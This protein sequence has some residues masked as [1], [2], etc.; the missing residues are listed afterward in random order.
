VLDPLLRREEQLRR[1]YG[2][3]ILARVPKEP[4]GAAG[5]PLSPAELTSAAAEAYRTLRGTLAV[6]RRRGSGDEE[7]R[8]I[9]ITGS[10]PAEGKTTT[11]INLATSLAAAGNSVILIEADL[12]R[13]AIGAALDIECTYGIVSV[14]IESVPLQDALVTSPAFG[15]NL[16]MLLADYEG[17]WISELFTLPAAPGLLDDARRLAD[18]VIVDSP[19]LSDV[20]DALPLATYVDEVLV[21][22]SI[23]RTNLSKLS[24]LGELLAENGIKPLGFAVLGVARPAQGYYYAPRDE[25]HGR[26]PRSLAKARP[27]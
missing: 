4:R 7:S 18:Y 19:P 5:K 12:R 23:G 2:L 21:V 9:L 20:I 25:G 11:A 24:Q 13:P 3:P 27:K 8:A 15:S 17:G 6:S 16:G 14:L 26:L 22:A 1:L 10:S